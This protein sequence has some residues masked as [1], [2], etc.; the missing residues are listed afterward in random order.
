MKFRNKLCGFLC[1]GALML[2][3]AAN[4]APVS[5][6]LTSHAAT[7]GYVSLDLTDTKTQLGDQVAN[8]EKKIA[9]KNTGEGDCKV[10]AKIFVAEK[11]KDYIKYSSDSTRWALNGDGYWYY[12]AVLKPGENT[13]LLTAKLDKDAFSKDFQPGE[14]D[15]FNI[16]VVHEYARVQY[17]DSGNGFVDWN[18]KIEIGQD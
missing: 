9:I 4:I 13:A 8:W 18:E 12:D 1:A 17:D 15:D 14:S 6:Y 2:T 11:Y 3:A 5:S 10:R 16:I 7:T